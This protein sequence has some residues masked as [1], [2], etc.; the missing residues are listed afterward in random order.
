[1]LRHGVDERREPFLPP[2]LV[3]KKTF[4]LLLRFVDPLLIFRQRI[5]FRFRS[6]QIFSANNGGDVCT[7]HSGGRGTNHSDDSAI[8]SSDASEPGR[9]LH[10]L[11]RRLQATRLA[12]MGS[13][14]RTAR[15]PTR[16]VL[17]RQR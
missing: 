16:T 5:F 1:M 12:S 2:S 3:V 9:L 7:N 11:W 14:A 8:C 15:L 4:I 17:R 6:N 13:P 10:R